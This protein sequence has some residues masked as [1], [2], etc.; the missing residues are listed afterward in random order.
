MTL[1]LQQLKAVAQQS[2][3]AT[4]EFAR[5]LIATPSLPG[6]E[7]NIAEIIKKEMTGL[8]YD[9][10][11]VDRAGNVIG[12]VNGGDGPSIMLNG[13]MDHVDPGPPEGWPYAPFAA[14]IVEGELWGRGA[15][16][17]K[18]PLACMIY[19]ASLFKQMQLTPP[20]DIYV[21]VAVME[22]I[23]G[24]GSQ[25]LTS[26][27]NTSLAICGEPSNNTLRHG[28]RGRVELIVEFNGHSA[29]ASAPHLGVNPHFGTAA[30]LQALSGLSL[31]QDNTLGS[32]TVVPT[33]YHNRSVQPQCDS[34]IGSTYP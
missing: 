26:H 28:H 31:A 12:K 29:H 24:L 22:E 10:T 17:M 9:K 23:G 11:W 33:L 8:G 25:H 4:V 21:T 13:H 6:E 34:G 20:G 27:L 32:S 19:A 15:V 5:H 16:D 7:A 2:Q 18:G 30:F 1:P 14:E 3:P